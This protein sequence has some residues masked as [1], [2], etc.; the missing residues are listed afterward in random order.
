MGTKFTGDW[1]KAP[2][3]VTHRLAPCVV[4]MRGA[5]R[6]L[7]AFSGAQTTA[8]IIPAS[9]VAENNQYSCPFDVR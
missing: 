2:L 7:K 1:T 8:L 5:S 9:Q 4:I 3:I 6:I